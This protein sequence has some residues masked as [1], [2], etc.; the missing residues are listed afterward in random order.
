M[1]ICQKIRHLDQWVHFTQFPMQ[2]FGGSGHSTCQGRD[3]KFP[4]FRPDSLKFAVAGTVSKSF[5]IELE[6]L[7]DLAEIFNPITLHTKTKLIRGFEGNKG[8]T[9]H[10]MFVHGPES[11]AP[12]DPDISRPEALAQTHCHVAIS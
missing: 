11:A 2:L 6:G 1:H 4:G 5:Q 3:D 12:L 8:R 9:R 7:P 10:Q